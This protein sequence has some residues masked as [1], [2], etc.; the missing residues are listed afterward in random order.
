M[1]RALIL[2][3][4]VIIADEPVSMVDASLRATIL[5]TLKNLNRE[6]GISILYITH[7]LATAYHI[8]D[9]ILVLYQGTV[10]EAGDVDSIILSPKHP[11]TQLLV[12]SIPWPDPNRRWGE[13]AI[14]SQG[15]VAGQSSQGC[16]FAPRCRHAMDI[17]WQTPPAM[18]Q[19]DDTRAVKCYLYRE[20]PAL[21]DEAV[22]RV[23]GQDGQA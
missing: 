23:L 15:D 3:P 18:Y 12:G 20:S 9:S 13:E 19:T 5:E 16:R 17:C 2:K 7:D 1:A 22:D 6:M 8:C 11:Y 10:A 14:I 21:G 4:Q